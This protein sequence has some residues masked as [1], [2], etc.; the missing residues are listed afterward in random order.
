MNSAQHANLV[1]QML[2]KGPDHADEVDYKHFDVQRNTMV[3]QKAEKPLTNSNFRSIADFELGEG[4]FLTRGRAAAL[5]IAMNTQI[6][7]EEKLSEPK[8]KRSRLN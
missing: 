3:R 8:I 1:K 7:E 2:S 5:G 6:L 4:D